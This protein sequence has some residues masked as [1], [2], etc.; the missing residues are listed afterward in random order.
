V[1]RPSP[2]LAAPGIDETQ[3]LYNIVTPYDLLAWGIALC[4][5]GLFYSFPCLIFDL[6]YGAHIGN[7]P[8]LTHTFIPLNLKSTEINPLYMDAFMATEVASCQM[9]S[10][11]M[12]PQAHSIFGSHFHTAPLGLVEKLGSS[13]LCLIFHHSKEDHLSESTNGWIDTNINAMKYFS[14]ADTADFVSLIFV[15]YSF[16]ISYIHTI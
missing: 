11:F 14:A 5:S 7:P 6:T 8:P 10:P 1:Q 4:D 3:C 13:A 15:L 16:S 9:D 12:V 2:H